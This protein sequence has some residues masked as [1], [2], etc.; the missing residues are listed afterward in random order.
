MSV[1]APR[2]M[3]PS[4]PA[5]AAALHNCVSTVPSSPGRSR[6]VGILGEQ[7]APLVDIAHVRE[8]RKRSD[9]VSNLQF[10]HRPLDL[11]FV[12][13]YLHLFP[14]KHHSAIVTTKS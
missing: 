1:A 14:Q 7:H 3:C 8:K 4:L 13:S 6:V 10:I 12:H 2:T 11:L 5:L 9:Y